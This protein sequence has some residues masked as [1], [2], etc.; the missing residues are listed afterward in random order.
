MA[1]VTVTL[2][3]N[4]LDVLDDLVEKGKVGSR[5]QAVREALEKFLKSPE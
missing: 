3:L 5:S 2:P 1:N 4:T